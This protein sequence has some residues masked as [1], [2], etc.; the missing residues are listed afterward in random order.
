M[1]VCVLEIE[2]GWV[3]TARLSVPTLLK[4]CVGGGGGSSSGCC[5]G[6]H[7]CGMCMR[8]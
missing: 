1:C 2:K 8:E 6:V 3:Y 4:S 5:V 7:V